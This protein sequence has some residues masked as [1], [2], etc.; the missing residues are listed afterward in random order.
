M[1]R[2]KPHLFQA[3]LSF[4]ASATNTIFPMTGS[5]P[6][7]IPAHEIV[8]AQTEQAVQQCYDVVKDQKFSSC[9]WRNDDHD[10]SSFLASG[11]FS[12]RTEISFGYGV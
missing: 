11:G 10:A 2:G 3:S 1:N 4:I 6:R 12:S 5:I 8:V 9:S 7:E